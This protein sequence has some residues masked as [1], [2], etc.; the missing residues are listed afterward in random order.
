M[1]VC[2]FTLAPAL[3][4]IMD[5]AD[6]CFHRMISAPLFFML[7]QYPTKKNSV[8][9]VA[10]NSFQVKIKFTSKQNFLGLNVYT[11]HVAHYLT[12][13]TLDNDPYL[14]SKPICFIS[15]SVPEAS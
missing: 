11:V 9:H 12:F 4:Y 7:F 14:I 1:R 15:N 13:K 5:L 3:A 6:C 10:V 2:T 8:F